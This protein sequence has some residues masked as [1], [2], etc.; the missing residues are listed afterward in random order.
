VLC[1]DKNTTVT[2]FDG[3]PLFSDRMAKIPKKDLIDFISCL[4]HSM[5]ITVAKQKAYA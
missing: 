1:K 5:A 3:K 2:D 4:E